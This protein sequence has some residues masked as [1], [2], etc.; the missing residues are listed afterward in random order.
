MDERRAFGS[1]GAR[2]VVGMGVL[3]E[4]AGALVRTWWEEEE[5]IVR[6]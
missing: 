4:G 1:R 3:E 6:A 2:E 5:G